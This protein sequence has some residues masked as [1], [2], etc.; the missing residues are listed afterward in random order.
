MDLL[1][2]RPSN[3]HLRGF[4]RPWKKAKGLNYLLVVCLLRL[5]GFS[6]LFNIQIR[7]L[8]QNL[9]HL[10][11]LRCDIDKLR[12]ELLFL[13]YHLRVALEKVRGH[14]FGLFHGGISYG[15]TRTL[16]FGLTVAHYC[17]S[18]ISDRALD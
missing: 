7:L 10:K 8:C 17:S 18:L 4:Y 12:F 3:L 5:I 15:L 2:L 6:I 1:F 9:R 16:P 14:S 13:L 11:L